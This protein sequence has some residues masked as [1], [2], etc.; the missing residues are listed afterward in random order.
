M[1]AAQIVKIIRFLENWLSVLKKTHQIQMSC[2]TSLQQEKLILFTHALTT[3]SEQTLSYHTHRLTLWGNAVWKP[4]GDS[5]QGIDQYGMFANHI[6]THFFPLLL[7]KKK[8]KILQ[9]LQTGLWHDHYTNVQ[10]K[11]LWRDKRRL[12]LLLQPAYTLT[13]NSPGFLNILYDMEIS[14]HLIHKNKTQSNSPV[15]FT[16][17][18]SGCCHVGTPQPSC[19]PSNTV[20]ASKPGTRTGNRSTCFTCGTLWLPV[21]KQTN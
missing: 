11:W 21:K 10:P 3:P 18:Q 15:K 12:L 17:S 4:A 6:F 16:V 7:K 8:K 5:S 20:Q 2:Q 14:R 13:E 1:F 19:L 9:H